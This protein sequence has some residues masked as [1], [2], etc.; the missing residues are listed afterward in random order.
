MTLSLRAQEYTRAGELIAAG[1][2]VSFPTETV[3]GLG[4]NALDP[5]AVE[6]I[7]RAKGRPQ[8]NPLIVH[9]PDVVTARAALN[10]DAHAAHLLLKC[11]APGPLTVVV[12][13]P[14][15]VPEVVRAGLPTVGLRVPAHPVARR[16]IAAAGVPVAAPSANRSGRPSPTTFPM[17]FSE[18]KGRISAVVDGGATDVGIESTVVDATDPSAVRILRP[19]T[20]TAEEIK[21]R[22]GL[23]V[24]IPQPTDPSRERVPNADRS[25][26]APPHDHVLFR[27]PGTRYRHYRPELPVIALSTEWLNAHQHTLTG[28]IETHA[29]HGTPVEAVLGPTFTDGIGALSSH[30]TCT[31]YQNWSEYAHHLYAHFWHAERSGCRLLYCHLPTEQEAP[32]LHDRLRRAAS[33]IR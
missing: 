14:P 16:I 13:S 27:S 10:E 21:R 6:A 8:D 2:L 26:V 17:A 20:I 7:F 23:T 4:A 33:E 3:Y 15:W 19:G 29:A 5:A 11:F 25:P 22:T 24:L 28:E 9:L 12:F 18:M 31:V 32:G 30:A 1:E